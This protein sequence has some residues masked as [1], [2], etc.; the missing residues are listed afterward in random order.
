MGNA[1]TIIGDDKKAIDEYKKALSLD[2]TYLL[3]LDNLFRTYRK[4][5]MNNVSVFLYTAMSRENPGLANS[6]LDLGRAYLSSDQ[7]NNVINLYTALLNIIPQ[8]TLQ[9]M[10][11]EIFNNLAI[12]HYRKKEYNFAKYYANK[13]V[14]AGYTIAP[15]IQAFLKTKER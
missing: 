8:E 6:L 15:E 2:P 12:A 14:D 13:A 10:N 9:Y 5:G 7:L 4:L 3:A 11:G 1:Y